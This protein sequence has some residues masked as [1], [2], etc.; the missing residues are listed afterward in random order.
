MNQPLNG[1]VRSSQLSD[2]DAARKHQRAVT[3]SSDFFEICGNDND[4]ETGRERLI[5][6]AVDF[7]LG[8]DIDA[9]SGILSDQN[10]PADPEPTPDYHL[11][12]IASRQ[13]LDRQVWVVRPKADLRGDASGQIGFSARRLR[14]RKAAADC[15]RVDERVLAD[16]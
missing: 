13:R 6:K 16:G 4:A 11:L 15:P 9:C 12:L 8:A 3:Q 5:E 10:A 7:G 2:D 14:R 1:E